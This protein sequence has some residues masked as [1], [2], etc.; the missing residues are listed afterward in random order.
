MTFVLRPG[1]AE[2]RPCVNHVGIRECYKCHS[3]DSWFCVDCDAVHMCHSCG[4][5]YC[6]N[7]RHCQAC[8]L[9]RIQGLQPEAHS[10]FMKCKCG[11]FVDLVDRACAECLTLPCLSPHL[12]CPHL[13]L[14]NWCCGKDKCW[15]CSWWYTDVRGVCSRI[16]RT[17]PVPSRAI[18]Q[19]QDFQVEDED[20]S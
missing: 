3:C 6:F 17:C 10:L 12:H 16:C 5:T 1:Y 20:L 18:L 9:R 13:T 8:A 7:C 19:I 11:Q 15:N 2:H 14:T 4:G